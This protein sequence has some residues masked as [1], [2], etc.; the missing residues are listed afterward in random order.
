MKTL[1]LFTRISLAVCL[2]LCL[3]ENEME[4]NVEEVFEEILDREKRDAMPKPKGMHLLY[5]SA[6]CMTNAMLVMERNEN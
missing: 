1:L 5:L 6:I 4:N 2:T 3:N